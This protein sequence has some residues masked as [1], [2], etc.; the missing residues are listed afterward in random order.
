LFIYV[1]EKSAQKAE[2]K[3]F[4]NMYLKTA[5]SIVPSVKYVALPAKAYTMALEHF[6][7]GKL[8]TVFKGHS[9]IGL[10]IEQLLKK[11]ATY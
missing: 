9:E 11:E 8:G 2:V 3:D 10:T 7:K 4:V 1:N 5:S 6:E